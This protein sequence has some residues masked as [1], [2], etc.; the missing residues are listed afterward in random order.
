M[1]LKENQISR[2]KLFIK[3]NS[4]LIIFILI[5]LIIS[6]GPFEYGIF[7]DEL[8]ALA[9]SDNPAFGYLDV[10][11]LGPF[12]LFLIKNIIGTSYFAL[13]L[14]PAFLGCVVLCLTDSIVKKLG[15]GKFAKVLALLCVTMAPQFVILDSM[16]TYDFLDKFFWV[17]SLYFFVS[18]VK[19]EDKKYLFYFGIAFGLGLLTKI[20]ILFLGFTLVIALLMTKKRKMFTRPALWIAAGIALGLF[21][22]YIIWQISR[23]LPFLE[24]YMNYAS[25]KTYPISPL[26]YLVNHLL[27]MNPFAILVWIPGLLYFF[28]DKKGREFNSIPITFLL[29]S[30]LIV[31]LKTKYF[32]SSPL[33]VFLFAGGAVGIEQF[34]TAKRWA[35]VKPLT[36]GL[37]GAG[38]LILLPLVRPVLPV[39]TFIQYNSA[40]GLSETVKYENH[41]RVVLPQHYADRFG[42]QEMTDAVANV[43]KNLSEKEQKECVILTFNYGRA[44]AV[45][46]YGKKYGL[47]KPVCGHLQYY[48]WGT[49][50]YTGDI[51]IALGGNRQLLS[52]FYTHI[53]QVDTFSNPY[54]MQYEN[55]IP[56]FLCKG[57]KKSLSEF[58]E[59]V[60]VFN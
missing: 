5:K 49:L 32:I 2:V 17:L 58:L 59:S 44:G 7:R 50:G 47:P 3:N 38:S 10:P 45:E 40:L 18:Y 55:N 16:Y 22:P 46:Y 53:D 31:V 27:T 4:I 30:V 33:F 41:E 21:L 42:W 20:T 14:L 15:G 1:I 56:I 43:F 28:L 23:G 11:P 54:V 12:L 19:D 35:W 60:K 13:H 6:L 9:M 34:I 36:L 8:Y 51:A 57:P 37:I 52:I 25:G 39:D 24:Y 26:D 48:L 29:L